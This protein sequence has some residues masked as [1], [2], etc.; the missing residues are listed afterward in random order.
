MSKEKKLLLSGR[1]VQE[2]RLSTI[3]AIRRSMTG[4]N[5]HATILLR[6]ILNEI[7]AEFGNTFTNEI[8]T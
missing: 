3:I 6:D 5:K 2:P 4:F 1:L 8:T 7:D